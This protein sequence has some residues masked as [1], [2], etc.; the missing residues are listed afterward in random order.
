MPINC[1]TIR[2]SEA[3]DAVAYQVN[4]ADAPIS[5]TKV[6]AEEVRRIANLPLYV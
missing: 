1:S 5:E 3:V 6:K 4:L 2:V